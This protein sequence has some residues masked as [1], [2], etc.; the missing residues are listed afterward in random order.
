MMIILKDIEEK[1][2]REDW[3]AARN[4]K[5]DLNARFRFYVILAFLLMFAAVAIKYINFDKLF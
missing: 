2:Y 3:K 1:S 5:S 4:A